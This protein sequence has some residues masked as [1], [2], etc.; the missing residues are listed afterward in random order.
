MP[1]NAS[2]P[3][4]DVRRLVDSRWFRNVKPMTT[5]TADGRV[6][7][8]FQV[9]ELPNDIQEIV[10]DGARLVKVSDLEEVTGLKKGM[11]LNPAVN[12]N[13]RL[14][15]LRRYQE[16]GYYWASVE[17]VEGDKPSDSRVVFRITEGPLVRVSGI[18]F[19]GID[20]V[21]DGRDSHAAPI[22][23]GVP[24]PAGRRLQPGHDRR[25]L[26]QA[27]GLLQVVRLSRRQGV[28]AAASGN[29]TTSAACASSSTS[30]KASATASK[31]VQVDGAKTIAADQL[32]S[33]VPVPKPASS[34]TIRS[35]RSAA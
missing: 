17:L 14:A 12:Q 2:R 11:K 28:A 1:Y 6:I 27:R 34:M 23:E 21:S 31:S 25:G 7:V 10:Y 19:S 33:Y 32:L 9:F 30:R 24:Q 13:A 8:I 22:L 20:F 4:E 18:S 35:S 15:I 5:P 29:R 16:K 3:S 26:P